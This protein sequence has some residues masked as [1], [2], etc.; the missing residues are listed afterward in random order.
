MRRLAYTL[1]VFAVLVAVGLNCEKE[2]PIGLYDPSASYN[3]DPV[4]TSIEPADSALAGLVTITINGQN[5]S[6]TTQYDLVYFGQTRVPVLEASAERLLVKSP[7]IVADAI[8]VKVAVI[9]A[10]SFS[11]VVNYKLV[12]GVFN[13]GGYGEFDEPYVLECDRDE[14]VY[15]TLGSRNVEKISPSGEKQVYGTVPFSLPSGIK[16]GP[17]GYLYV[18]RRSTSFYRIPPGGG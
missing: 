17:G 11:N 10:L 9:G 5:F 6:P 7:N 2:K 16:F 14:N 15:V 4:I 18:G 8:P 3:P 13:W 1:V 12:R